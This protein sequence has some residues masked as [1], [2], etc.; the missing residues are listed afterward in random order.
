MRTSTCAAAFALAA[1]FP[2][3]A[4]AQDS[5]RTDGPEGSEVGKGGYTRASGPGSFSLSVQWGAA[6][7]SNAPDA[8]LFVGGA[9]DYWVED[10]FQVELSG[11]YLFDT[12]RGQVMIGPRFHSFAW[13]ISLTAAVEAGPIFFQGGTTRFG[14]SPTAGAEM[15]F[16]R[17]ALVGLHYAVD[18]PIP[19]GTVSQRVFL[20]AGWRF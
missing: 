2:A 16:G 14:L 10:W 8:P 3:A 4:P 7:T 15:L 12:K 20:S 11:A 13:P 1:L 19:D 9:A 6:V 5:G 17:H 18:I